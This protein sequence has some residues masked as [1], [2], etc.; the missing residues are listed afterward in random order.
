[1]RV[2]GLFQFLPLRIKVPLPPPL[3]SEHVRKLFQN[4]CV[5]ERYQGIRETKS[6]IAV[7]LRHQGVAQR[8]NCRCVAHVPKAVRRAHPYDWNRIVESA[9]QKRSEVSRFEFPESQV[10]RHSDGVHGVFGEFGDVWGRL[11]RAETDQRP[12]GMSSN[13]F[14]PAGEITDQAGDVAVALVLGYPQVLGTV[15]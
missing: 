8:W 4:V 9:N 13:E 1:L 7:L 14:V 2:R 11:F 5:A 6:D 10:R 12:G 15:S 3:F